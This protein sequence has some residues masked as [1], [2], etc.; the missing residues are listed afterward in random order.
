MILSEYQAVWE[1]TCVI[2]ELRSCATDACFRH[3]S[4]VKPIYDVARMT[5]L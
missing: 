1:V 2:Y 5:C 3:L 4:I